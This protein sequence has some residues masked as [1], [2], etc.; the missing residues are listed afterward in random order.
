LRD[1]QVAGQLGLEPTPDE[2]VRQMVA[3]FREVRRV[4]RSDG[5]CWVNL[6]DSYAHST[7]GGGGAVDVRTDGRNTTPGDK[8]RGRTKGTN[9]MSDGLKPK[10]LIGIPWR[11]ALALQAD[12]WWLRSDI[13]WSKPNPMPESV[14]DRPT[15]SHEY[16]FLLAKSERYYFDAEALREKD[17]GVGRVRALQGT[18]IR[19]GAM[20]RT[21]SGNEKSGVLWADTGYRN[22]RTVWSIPTESYPGLH[23]ATYP[24]RLVEPCIKA[25]TSERGVCPECGAPWERIVER[26]EVKLRPKSTSNRGDNPSLNRFICGNSSRGSMA[27]KTATLGWRP[28]CSHGGDPVPA[29][30][31]DPFVGSGTTLVVATNLGRHGIGLD[32]SR[33]YLVKN[34]KRRIERPHAPVIRAERE[35]EHLP[36]FDAITSTP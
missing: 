16:L 5:S 4:L 24:R 30:V 10:D 19:A 28:T 33:Q 32:L 3:V 14:T 26:E 20:G 1:Y 6:G 35:D 21:P 29:T 25:G 36:L 22:I 11:V 12:R 8:V 2:Y 34:A 13:I 17:S 31:F 23:Y 27:T 18:K 9:T 7:S 15:K